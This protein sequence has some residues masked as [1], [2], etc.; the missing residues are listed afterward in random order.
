MK[1]FLRKFIAIVLVSTFVALNFSV[2]VFAADDAPE[3]RPGILPTAEGEDVDSCK[4]LFEDN[5]SSDLR[6]KLKDRKD[7]SKILGCGIITGDIHMWMVP[8]YIRYLLEFIIGIA[9]LIAVGGI[10]YGGFVYIFS[11]VSEDTDK[12]K[13]AITYGIIGMVLTLLSWAIVNIVIALVTG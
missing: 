1:N 3:T 9:G 2:V 5:T 11:G 10:V 7:V 8:Y 13:K 4:K 12:G 6:A